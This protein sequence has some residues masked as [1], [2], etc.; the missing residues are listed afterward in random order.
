MLTIMRLIVKDTIKYNGHINGNHITIHYKK[1]K[2]GDLVLKCVLTIIKASNIVSN[3]VSMDNITT[4]AVDSG[5]EMVIT[6]SGRR[7]VM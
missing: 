4:Y 5:L 7:D 6:S 2:G 1:S 3:E